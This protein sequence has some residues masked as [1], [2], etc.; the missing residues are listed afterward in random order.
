MFF[1]KGGS[2]SPISRP[3]QHGL[4]RVPGRA[5]SS[6]GHVVGAQGGHTYSRLR[7]PQQAPG[8]GVRWDGAMEVVGLSHT[9]AT[10]HPDPGLMTFCTKP[11]VFRSLRSEEMGCGARSPCLG[12]Q[13]GL[14]QSG[15]CLGVPGSLG[16]QSRRPPPPSEQDF[17]GSW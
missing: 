10:S 5:F 3:V 7:C 16:Q 8:T 1:I 17:A 4:L 9:P 14:W 12:W 11:L 15:G 13:C 2:T 6:P